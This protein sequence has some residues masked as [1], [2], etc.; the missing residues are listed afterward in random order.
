M[1][2]TTL[3]LSQTLSPENPTPER[4]RLKE[5][6]TNI[7]LKRAPGTIRNPQ[8]FLKTSLDEFFQNLPAEVESYLAEQAKAYVDRAMWDAPD[9][10]ISF[11]EVTN[12]LDR[13]RD[14][15]DL[16]LSLDD[17]Q[18]V[19]RILDSVKQANPDTLVALEPC[20]FFPSPKW[21]SYR[22]GLST[23]YPIPGWKDSRTAVSGYI[24]SSPGL[25]TFLWSRPAK[26]AFDTVSGT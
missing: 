5:W 6:A 1:Q 2:E 21:Q 11:L 22:H 12:L 15:R 7:I 25:G 26:L 13:L 24:P 10:P 19:D 4:E 18:I 8:A 16:P 20:G 17:P 14:E 9:L 3:H 23:Q